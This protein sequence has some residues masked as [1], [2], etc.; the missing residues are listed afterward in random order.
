MA[1][2]DSSYLQDV[3]VRCTEQFLN[4]KIPLNESLAKEASDHGL[5]SDQL[6]RCIEAANTVTHLKLMSLVSDRTVEFPLAK[7]AEVMDL[8]MG[9]NEPHLVEGTTQVKEASEASTSLDSLTKEAQF[10]EPKVSNH[11]AM[12]HFIKEAAANDLRLEHLGYES[13]K[14][15]LNLMKSAKL[16]EQDPK[17]LDKMACVLGPEF[18][19]LS[20]LVSGSAQVK[21]DFGEASKL[22][23]KEAELKE[24]YTLAELYKQA[25]EIL[26][27]TSR[28]QDLAVK[29][30]AV[31]EA[32]KDGMK[33]EMLKQAGLLTSAASVAGRAADRVVGVAKNLR[34]NPVTTISKGVGNAA[35]YT[36]A[37]PVKAVA[38]AVKGMAKGVG[39]SA[40]NAVGPGA[41]KAYNSVVTPFGGA[42]K[43]FTPT[44]SRI[45]GAVIGAAGVLGTA[46]LDASM[47]PHPGYDSSTG[48]SRDVWEGLK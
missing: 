46:A 36:A 12:I 2:I 22:M 20:V 4:N 1:N 14:V 34:S 35:F 19:P 32:Y 13:E 9:P 23:F 29:A 10:V 8:I 15:R 6:Q 18:G 33:T 26:S 42:A 47:V 40:I 5:N 41:T 48:A 43:T 28:R 17:G 24:V 25:Q 44:K 38:G 45:G 16:I 31:K 27:E 7:Y 21:R 37:A 3:A 11:E 30:A 39:R